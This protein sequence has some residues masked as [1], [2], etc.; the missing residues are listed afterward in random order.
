MDDPTWE[1][2]D[3]FDQLPRQLLKDIERFFAIY[4]AGKS[5]FTIEGWEGREAAER[6]I[7]AAQRRYRGE[8]D[9]ESA[10]V[11]PCQVII[12]DEDEQTRGRLAALAGEE[13]YRI[14]AVGSGREAL[15]V[16]E[17]EAVDLVVT[18]LFMTDVDGWEL[19]DQIKDRHPL[20]H[21]VVTT[22]NITEQGAALLDTRK[23]DGYLVKP[24]QKRPLQILFRALLAPG[25]LD[26][27][28]DVVVVSADQELLQSIDKSLAER[29]VSVRIF[30][31]VGT[32]VPDIW[33]DPPD[34]ALIDTRIGRDSGFKLCE[35]IRSSLQ[36]PP[37]P[38]LLLSDG[39]SPDEV[40]RAV[41]LRIDGMLLKPFSTEN[42]IERVFK[43]LR[44]SLPNS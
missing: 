19:L 35:R 5:E 28:A 44:M 2:L 23:A 13:G 10:P 17:V 14:K 31:K 24:V 22:A 40:H 27:A 7:E 37:I 41:R 26:R 15:D 6:E 9:G 42:L 36:I 1:H 29:G 4:N 21:V 32:A 20:T 18:E 39:S 11:K 25:N 38:I 43:L 12:V 8:G 3:R 34:L 16:L 30:G 33:N